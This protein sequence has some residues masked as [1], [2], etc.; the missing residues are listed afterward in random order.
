MLLFSREILILDLEFGQA[1]GSFA[2]EKNSPSFLQI[3]PCKFRDAYFCLLNN[4]S[5]TLKLRRSPAS[6]PYD[7]N[8]SH[9]SSRLAPDIYYDSKCHSDVIRLSRPSHIMGFSVCPKNEQQV[10]LLLS[11]G[12]VLFWELTDEPQVKTMDG[13]DGDR[14]LH[15]GEMIPPLVQFHG[16]AAVPTKQPKIKFMLTG[17]YKGVASNPT[18]L[19]MCPPLTTKNWA[20]YKPFAAVGKFFRALIYSAM[21]YKFHVLPVNSDR[22]RCKIG[23]TSIHSCH[24]LIKWPKVKCIGKQ[25]F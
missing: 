18:C 1:V 21:L 22:S 8:G 5:V 4:G 10:S 6:V 11:D 24:S 14:P 17:M 7:Q 25:I 16:T 9:A 23:N 3:I 19:K 12:R 2:V 15:L 20:V 13:S